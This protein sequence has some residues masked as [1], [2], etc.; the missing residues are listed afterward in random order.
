MISKNKVDK[1]GQ[2]LSSNSAQYNLEFLEAE[3]IFDEYRKLHLK[4]LSNTTLELQDWLNQSGTDYYIAQRLKR[5][6]QILRKLNRF[7]SRLT[8]LQDVGGSRVI[9]ETNKMIQDT[10]PYT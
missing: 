1:A 10:E 8:Q 7:K 4:P 5:K 2:Y 3:E 6:P 9:V